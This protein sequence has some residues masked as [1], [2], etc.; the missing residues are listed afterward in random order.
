[1]APGASKRSLPA[2]KRLPAGRHGLAPEIVR[3]HQRRRLIAAMTKQCAEEG[4]A[5][6]TV[7]DVATAAAVSRKAFYECFENK[8]ACLF[9]AYEELR[10]SLF[11]A[12]DSACRRQR[13]RH[14][15]VAAALQAALS[16]FA[17][18][19]AAAKLLSFGI[20]S[21][22]PSGVD[23]YYEMI[24]SLASRLCEPP[25]EPAAPSHPGA[26]WGTIVTTVALVGRAATEGGSSPILALEGDL[27]P[28]LLGP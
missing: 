23:R 11:D 1:M 18:D 21:A 14:D 7:G 17:A 25:A 28:M 13:R 22:G 12:I 20:V 6:T 15:K 8:E 27:L 3:Q 2:G 19:P 24:D 9:A 10:A 4:Y 26:E 16:L 5:T